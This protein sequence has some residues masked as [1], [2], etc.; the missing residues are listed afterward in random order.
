MWV[1]NQDQNKWMS[2]DIALVRENYYTVL[3]LSTS[4]SL[5]EVR[6]AYWEFSK[7]YHPDTTTLPSDVAKEKFQQ[8]KE[9]YA[10]LSDPRQRAIYD[11]QL[12][13]YQKKIYEQ[14]LRSVRSPHHSHHLRSAHAY[15]DPVDRP[16]SA[17]E[18]SALFFMI[19]TVVGCVLL[20]IAIAVIRG[21]AALEPIG[22][23]PIPFSEATYRMMVHFS[24]G[25]GLPMP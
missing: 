20:A 6:K 8:I 18:I 11:Q 23:F 13:F 16:L 19:I 21:D 22:L 25:S 14:Q 24:P 9:A 2:S 1:E 4:A 12:R 10:T 3:G 7:R 5:L 15:L 17:G